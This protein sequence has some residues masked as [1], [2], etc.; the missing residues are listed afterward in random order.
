MPQ[1]CP[2]ASPHCAS[3][4]RTREFEGFYARLQPTPVKAPSLLLFNEALAADLGMNLAAGDHDAAHFSGNTLFEGSEPI[5]QAYAGHQFGGFSPQLGDGRAILLG[6]VIDPAGRRFDLQLKGSGPTP[7]SRRG[8]GRAALGPVL[9]EYLVSE[10]MQAL[11]VPTTR[12]LAATL[13]GERVYRET[14]L[15]GAILA[16]VASS[17]LR[18]GTFQFFAGNGGPDAVRRL[19]DHVIARH[20]PDLADTGNRYLALLD[21]VGRRQAAL[22]ARWMQIGFVH[23][24][25]NTDNMTVSGETI[26]YGP[27][28]FIDAFDP[29]AVFSSIDETGRYQYSNQPPIGQWNLARLAETLL[30]LID[31]DQDRSIELATGSLERYMAHYDAQWLAGMAAKLGI[32]SAGPDDKA[33]IESLL[34]VMDQGEADFTLTFRRLAQVA[35]DPSQE[36]PF[37]AGF[38]D[39]APAREWLSRWQARLRDDPA[40]PGERSR[41]MNQVNPAFIARNHRVEQVLAAAIDEG[42]LAPFHR[43]AGILARPFD[44]QPEN[45]EYA[46]GPQ[47]G[48]RPY[49]TF[50]GT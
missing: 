22:I 35:K 44:E 37:L 20:Y 4:T 16:R 15:P 13:T 3:T 18:V 45:A 21:A 28:A 46:A 8:D 5:A 14:A 43:L 48:G 9:R 26:D 38:G 23:G 36:A 24:V 7:Y 40:P 31:A 25:M 30:P 6:E 32:E 34:S 17:H 11:G 33:L 29:D 41:R 49:R 47:P 12:A 19:A 2:R 50:C 39:A 1:T 10:A 27:C 42:D